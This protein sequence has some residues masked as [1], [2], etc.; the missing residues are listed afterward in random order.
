[1]K[2]RSTGGV[3]CALAAVVLM[4]L[5][6][7]APLV[8]AEDSRP[9]EFVNS[10]GMSFRL[11]SG[12]TFPMGSESVASQSDE[13]PIHDVVVSSFYMGVFEVSQ[14]EYDRVMGSNPSEYG[15]PEHPVIRVT[16]ENA[17]DFC[18]R[19]SE[20]E[21][22]SYRLPTEAEWE[23]AARAG[24]YDWEYV[25]GNERTPLINDVAHAN[26]KDD[27]FAEVE[28]YGSLLYQFGSPFLGYDDGFE[29]L[30]PVGSFP[31]ND[32]GLHDMGGNVA[33]WC[34]DVYG[35]YYYRES[36]T[37]NPTGPESG[38]DRVMRGGSW[39]AGEK[40]ARVTGRFR[41]SAS[42]TSPSIG[43]RCMLEVESVQ[44]AAEVAGDG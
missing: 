26:V 13:K 28:D 8:V 30:A 10:L 1:M 19:L 38:P 25:W 42:F 22:R 4:S 15:E 6:V 40:Y 7:W 3:V 17:V 43:F 9:D 41:D 35:R 24:H 2:S 20:L 11:M 14:D 31:A 12:G 21:G 39:L 5:G 29:D 33:E 36:T 32:F 27:S 44:A 34:L 18:L 37:E 23:Y 16:W